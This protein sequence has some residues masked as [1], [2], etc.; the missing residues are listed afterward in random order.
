M[1][2]GKPDKSKALVNDWLWRLECIEHEFERLIPQPELHMA[3]TIDRFSQTDDRQTELEILLGGYVVRHGSV[4]VW[5]GWDEQGYLY[6]QLGERE[7][8]V[9]L[10]RDIEK[11]YLCEGIPE[12]LKEATESGGSMKWSYHTY[13]KLPSYWQSK[14]N[15]LS[16]LESNLL[17][18]ERSIMDTCAVAP[19]PIV[20]KVG[21]LASLGGWS[22]ALYYLALRQMHPFLSAW[23][24]GAYPRG[25]GGHIVSY[26]DWDESTRH[27]SGIEPDLL[28]ATKYAFE[29]FRRLAEV[30]K[31]VPPPIDTGGWWSC[32]S[33]RKLR[34]IDSSPKR[35][36]IKGTKKNLKDLKAY[37]KK[38]K[39]PNI[40]ETLYWKEGRIKTTIPFK[41]MFLQ[42]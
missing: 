28:T 16:S 13:V 8:S 39:R 30:E 14:K 40:A 33:L 22:T 29:V 1:A 4:P 31:V 34:D 19:R 18:I 27:L 37:L 9:F 12:D 3:F 26:N 23:H 2:K 6:L 41:R 36:G 15:D 21:N 17:D 38:H 7:N 24:M 32:T 11:A 25:S 5:G 35:E 20:E 42:H 10:R